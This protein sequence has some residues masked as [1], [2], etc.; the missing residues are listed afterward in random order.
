[1]RG[2]SSQLYQHIME[3]NR[4]TPYHRLLE[5]NITE[6]SEGF[7]RAE[8]KVARKHMNPMDITHG[9]VGFSI[10]DVVM[11]TAVTTTGVKS[12][13]VEMNINYFSP[14]FEGDCLTAEG[15]IIRQGKSI[16]VAE[17]ELL[18]GNEKIAISRQTMKNLGKLEI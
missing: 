12:T 9:G 11:G 5:M 14:S 18:K 7:C 17:G 2:I 8:L 3:Q 15:W 1:M 4:T 13:T 16:I 6:L 10:L